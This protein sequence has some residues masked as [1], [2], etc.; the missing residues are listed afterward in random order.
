MDLDLEAM[1]NLPPPDPD[2][3]GLPV[4]PGVPLDEDVPQGP[5][6]PREGGALLRNGVMFK[7]KRRFYGE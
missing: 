5:P 2:D 1:E 3:A 6:A 4:V 7:P